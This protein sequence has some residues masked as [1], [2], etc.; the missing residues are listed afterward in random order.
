MYA[1]FL[2]PE[3]KLLYFFISY[4]TQGI[5]MAEKKKAS[6]F[7]WLV[8]ILVVLGVYASTLPDKT[9][10]PSTTPALS[11][12]Q[13]INQQLALSFTQKT[14]ENG[15]LNV[16]FTLKNNSKNTITNPTFRCTEFSKTNTKLT[17][18]ERIKYESL[19]PGEVGEYTIDMGLSHPAAH[20]TQCVVMNFKY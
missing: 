14:L 9:F 15:A 20:A 1:G 17:R 13:Q 5:T 19:A 10:T 18:Y 4:K 7:T 6:R 16:A 11:Q 8:I 3:I 2:M 12:Y